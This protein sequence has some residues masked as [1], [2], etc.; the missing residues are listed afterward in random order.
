M[1]SGVSHRYVM[2]TS[3]TVLGLLATQALRELDSVERPVRVVPSLWV[4]KQ[5]SSTAGSHVTI[6]SRAY[7]VVD[8]TF[9]SQFAEAYEA[10]AQ[11][12]K[13]LEQQFADILAANLWN[14]YA[15]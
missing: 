3:A 14:L 15:R 5:E 7:Q 11:G 4:G 12:Q 10:F 6:F 8:R 1:S 9:E 2:G 13:R